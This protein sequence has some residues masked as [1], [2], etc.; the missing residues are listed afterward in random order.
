MSEGTLRC[1]SWWGLAHVRSWHP[2]AKVVLHILPRTEQPLPQSVTLPH[3]STVLTLHNP[4]L[5]PSPDFTAEKI[6][7]GGGWKVT[8]RA[9]DGGCQACP[10]GT[11]EEEFKGCTL[12]LLS[13]SVG[14]RGAIQGASNLLHQNTLSS[15]AAPWLD[16]RGKKKAK[17]FSSSK[18]PTLT[19]FGNFPMQI[20]WNLGECAEPGY[21]C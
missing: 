11:R 8:E 9:A 20:R 18:F 12:L 4:H 17:V 3:R 14:G 1:H 16:C 21:V 6:E 13:R 10:C 15:G 7:W 2:V 5:D 19:P